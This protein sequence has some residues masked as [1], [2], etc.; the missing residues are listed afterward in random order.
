MIKRLIILSAKTHCRWCIEDI[1]KQSDDKE[2]ESIIQL[3]VKAAREKG[4]DSIAL[5]SRSTKW[6]DKTNE[7]KLKCTNYAK[8]IGLC[9]IE[10]MGC[11]GG[12]DSNSDNKGNRLRI[13]DRLCKFAGKN[14]DESAS[15]DVK[16]V[17]SDQNR[18]NVVKLTG[19]VVAARMSTFEN[20]VVEM[21]PGDEQ[22]GPR[23][24]QIHLSTTSSIVNDQISHPFCYCMLCVCSVS[25]TIIPL[26]KI[27]TYQMIV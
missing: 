21:P 22:G 1:Y 5:K 17:Q 24:V 9:L 13:I 6:K 11:L 7:V 16:E 14:H 18:D 8:D 12:I 3:F 2:K 26:T 25:R 19:A 23:S 10:S 20:G 15:D 27:Q 4:F